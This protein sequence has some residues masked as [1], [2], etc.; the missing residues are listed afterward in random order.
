MRHTPMERV[1]HNDVNEHARSWKVWTDE[2]IMLFKKLRKLYDKDY[3]AYIPH[4]KDR[5]YN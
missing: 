2:E 1:I 3:N 5:T 4:F